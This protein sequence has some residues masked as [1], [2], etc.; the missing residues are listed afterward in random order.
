MKKYILLPVL[1]TTVLSIPADGQTWNGSVSSDWNTAANWTPANVPAPSGNVVINNAAALYQPVLAGNVNIAILNMSAGILNL[2]SYSLT[3]SSNASFSG[4]SLL[5]GKIT[6]NNFTHMANMHMGGKIIFEK[7]GGANGFWEGNN[8]VYN[9]TLIVIWRWGAL[10]LQTAASAPDSIFSHFKIQLADDYSVGF[11]ENSPLYVQNDL[12]IDNTG[13]GT[14]LW[15]VTDSTVIGGNLV[16]LNF[17][18]ATPNLLLKNI[19]TLGN[20]ANGPFYCYTGSINNCSF[21]GNFTLV[22]DSSAGFTINS[23]SF[24]GADNLFQA[25]TF[26]IQ[27]S[28]F[29]QTGS[30]VTVLRAAS[31]VAGS[32]FFRDGNN[33]FVGDVQYE[34]YAAYPAG[35]TFQQTFYGADTCLG[36]M[37][38]VLQENTALTTNGAG[39]SYVAGNVTIDAQGTAKGVQFTG[40]TGISFNI[41]GDFVAKNFTPFYASGVLHTNVILRNLD[42]AGTDTCG[43]FYCYTGNITNCSFNGNVKLIADSSQVYAITNSSLY[44]ANNLFQAG[45]LTIQNSRF[46]QTATGTT[47][48]KAAHNIAGNVYMRDGSNKFF[49]DVQW[50]AVAPSD[51]TILFQ[52]TFYGADTCLG[53]IMVNLAGPS[54]ADLGSNNL[55][56]EKG[57]SL[58]NNGSGTI[59]HNTGAS[60][61]HFVG[62]DTAGYSFNGSGAAPSIANIEMNRQGGLQLQSPLTCSGTLTFTRGIILSSPSNPLR[63]LNGAAVSNAWDSSYVDGPV[64]KTGNTAFTFPVGKNNV[65][66]PI[67]ITAPALTTDEFSA[68]YFYRI[69]HDDGYDSTQH[70]V[71]LHHLSRNEYWLLNRTA[72]TSS[73]KVTLS[74]ETVRSGG[75]NVIPDLRVARWNGTTW[76]DEGNGGTSGTTSEGTI[77]SLNTITGFSPFTLA[78]ST[79]FN[80]LPVNYIYFTVTLQPNK[81]ALLKWETAE[82]ISN[83]FFEIEKSTDNRSWSVIARVN[84]NVTHIYSFTDPQ[85][86]KGINY[87]R[88]RQVD[89][90]GSYSYTAVRLIKIS[91]EHKLFIW[92]NP[93]TGNLNIQTPFAEGVIEIYEANDK[94]VWKKVISSTV[95]T[96]PVQDLAKGLYIIQ[97]RYRNDKL[98]EKFIKE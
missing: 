59:V 89:G 53:N 16:A 15:N 98:T 57:L 35:I 13:N 77:Q 21:N 45:N 36:N 19:T 29:G 80:P 8:K 71:S 10:H 5:N 64:S 43:T 38:F 83:A 52:Q 79:I 62:I 76:K 93:V 96:V 9:D 26:S 73:A 55:Y 33:K 74:W 65:Y 25:Q 67:S 66:A 17:S 42:V 95:N 14:F 4:D 7:T 28:R 24:S 1:L 34:G 72:G 88:I 47:I 41:G 46:G 22:G 2:N 50:E 44:G 68:Q 39:H 18:S 86:A 6:A 78:S 49:G 81:T 40:G 85:P 82:E 69:A 61:I 32:T 84:T 23:S 11:A 94:M 48:L 37:S 70:D 54:S 91:S 31:K 90:D 75:V 87:Y 12:I 3:C 60:A 20:N 63:I 56:L 51:G 92:P 58:H 97:V 27:N 30:G